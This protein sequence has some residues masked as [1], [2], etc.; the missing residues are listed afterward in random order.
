MDEKIIWL[1]T[2]F[3]ALF[4]KIFGSDTFRGFDFAPNK[5]RTV[6]TQVSP[7]RHVFE[8]C[9]W[10]EDKSSPLDLESFMNDGYRKVLALDIIWQLQQIAWFK[11]Y[12]DRYDR[13]KVTSEDSSEL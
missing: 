3:P 5:D 8:P 11:K 10:T 13:V 1:A 4:E 9:S 6:W 12:T 2:E 7:P